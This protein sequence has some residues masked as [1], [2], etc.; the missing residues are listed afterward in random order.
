METCPPSD[1]SL[2]INYS[3]NLITRNAAR[4]KPSCTKSVSGISRFIK[5]ISA[6]RMRTGNVNPDFLLSS[7]F[8]SGYPYGALVPTDCVG[9]LLVDTQGCPNG[10]IVFWETMGLVNFY[11]LFMDSLRFL[12]VL[13][14]GILG[15]VVATSSMS[16]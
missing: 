14:Y 2:F 13:P 10:D 1:C 3:A 6:F 7:R 8:F 9:V 16:L 11:P 12:G 4:V 5:C 15:T